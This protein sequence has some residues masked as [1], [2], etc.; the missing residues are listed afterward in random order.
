MASTRHHGP[1]S[2]SA[3]AAGWSFGAFRGP[4]ART[5]P[6]YLLLLLLVTCAMGGGS[7]FPDVYSLLYV[8]PV[9]I[10]C[11]VAAL[12]VPASG[13][14]RRYRAPLLLFGL[15]ALLMVIQLV[16]LPPS[17]WT[18]LPGRAPYVGIAALAGVEQPWRPI[19][20]TP[21]LTLNSLAALI[22]PAAVLAAFPKLTSEQRR[23]TV[24][25]LIVLCA[26]SAVMGVLQFAGGTRSALYW[27]Q[28]T[29]RGFP[30]GFLSNRNHQAVL[31][32][33]LFPAL[34]VWTLSAT[35][36]KAWQQRRQ[37]LA[38]ALGVFVLPVILA[39]GSRAGMMVTLLSIASTFALFPARR[40]SGERSAPRWRAW[41]IGVGV[42]VALLLLIVLTYALGR[43]AS[44]DRFLSL[45]ALDSDQR[46]LYAPIVLGIVKASFP[47]GTG[48]GSF[49]P[50]FRQYEPDAILK[51]SFY[52]HAHNE[53]FELAMMAGLAGLLLLAAFLIWWAVRMITT[54]RDAGDGDHHRLVRLGGMV[55]AFVLL[56][57]L[58]D[59]PLRAPL[60]AAVFTL[61]C[62]LLCERRA[63]A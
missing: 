1:R 13:N 8:R 16:P 54:L 31:L 19:S 63:D 57:S 32:A 15:F 52:N 38:L 7:S 4:I 50:I 29:Y 17:L 59:Y 61:A 6:F 48:F 22:I 39:T 53:L 51:S 26:C 24:I 35:A 34:R 46:F 30:V 23:A 5:A 11:F 62:C 47:I 10:L 41:A 56:A 44:I 18:A 3:S 43:A 58:F 28:R 49:D 37:W 14:W 21:D 2:R 27:Y 40:R 45:S 42:P 36:N 25:V 20:L 60:M 12:L 55:I 9:A 33:L